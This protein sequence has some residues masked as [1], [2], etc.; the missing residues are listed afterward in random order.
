MSIPVTIALLTYNRSGYL[1]EAI[2]GVLSQT[3]RNF[4]FLILDNG[5]TDDTPDVV[6]GIKDERVRYVRNP[7][8]Y[9]APFNGASAIKIARGERVIATH[10]DD[11]MM[12]TMLEKQMALMDAHPGM[13]AVWTNVCTI[14]KDGAVMS[15][16]LTPLGPDRI[17]E[18][19]E[20]IVRYPAELLWPLPST[21]IFCRKKLSA[22]LID[23]IY[24]GSIQGGKAPKSHGGLDILIPSLLNTRGSIGF[25]NEPLLK[26]RLHGP[27][28]SHQTNISL[29]PLNTYS[30]LYKLSRKIP[31]TKTA[32][33]FLRNFALRYKAQHVVINTQKP[34]LPESKIS[35]LEKEFLLATQDRDAPANAVQPL[36]PLSIFLSQAGRKTPAILDAYQPPSADQPRVVQSLFQWIGRRKR[37][38]NL[39]Q[40][41]GGKRVAILGSALISAV[42]I[43]E[44][45]EAGVSVAYCLDSNIRRQSQTM[46]GVPIYPP[47]H[48]G[49]AQAQVDCVILSSERE[50]DKYLV[51]MIRKI[52]GKVEVISWKDLTQSA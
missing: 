42:L 13:T 9:T 7:P 45:R 50:H 20:Y 14:D 28:D 26:Y 22:S 38:E 1:K 46:L 47:S 31:Q 52:N 4:E 23:S 15:P 11:I 35:G 21:L 49:T 43:N 17:Y 39:F 44:V 40:R 12:P 34:K 2:E 27:Q 8:G 19:G 37:G 5:S 29:D 48:L 16:Y 30:T 51:E 33:P 24:Y 41:F 6:L 18:R 10:D 36:L 32:T 25:L 3:Y